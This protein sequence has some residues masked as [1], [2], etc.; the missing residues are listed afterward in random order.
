MSAGSI[1]GDICSYPP[2]SPIEDLISGQMF[3]VVVINPLRVYHYTDNFG[4]CNGCIRGV[5]FCY[6]PASTAAT[7]EDIFTI[8]IRNNGGLIV[9]SY[10]IT[11]HPMN[12]RVNCSERYNLFHTDCCIEQILPMPFRVS[13]NQY[14]ALRMVSVDSLLLRHLSETTNGSKQLILMN[15]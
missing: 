15:L 7:T 3:Q 11:V 8:E 14:Y 1:F 10:T 4:D 6:R 12:D 5:T 9:E 13:Q 2:D